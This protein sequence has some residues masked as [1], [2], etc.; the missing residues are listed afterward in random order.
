MI[1]RRVAAPRIEPVTLG[2]A[3]A[4]CR[5]EVSEDDALLTAL[6]VA[7]REQGET[8]TGRVFV[9][10]SWRI[11]MPGPLVSPVLL[12]LAPVRE[13][14]AVTVD[15]AEVDRGL[16]S[17]VPSGLSPQEHPVRGTFT[18]LPGFPDGAEVTVRVKAGWPVEG[19]EE[20]AR[21]T[22]PHAI[23]QWMLVRIGGLYAQRETFITGTLVTRM[24]RDFVDCL[25]DPYVMVGA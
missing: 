19:D 23:R 25:L 16:Y 18:P 9:D 13:V 20:N 24:T 3:K 5:V 22:T 1:I 7:V 8:L 2:E 21:A 14:E 6:I 15:G 10:S 12:S 4:H 17:L 11:T